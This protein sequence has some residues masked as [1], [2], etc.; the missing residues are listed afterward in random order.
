MRGWGARLDVLMMMTICMMFL[1]DPVLALVY[2]YQL[3]SQNL[4]GKVVL[5]F[6]GLFSSKPGGALGPSDWER[7]TPVNL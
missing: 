1:Y 2:I 5:T 3:G 7:K 6:Q 4:F